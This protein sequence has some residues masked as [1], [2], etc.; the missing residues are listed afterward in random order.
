MVQ[1][2]FQS[3]AGTSNTWPWARSSHPGEQWPRAQASTDE[4]E[5]SQLCSTAALVR[6]EPR[7]GRHR[8]TLA[9]VPSPSSFPSHVQVSPEPC[10]RPRSSQ[11]LLKCPC[12]CAPGRAA[13][14][15]RPVPAHHGLCGSHTI[16]TA[17]QELLDSR[18][19]NAE[20]STRSGVTARV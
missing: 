1:K 14:P 17:E 20:G 12:P 3:L 18:T 11:Q 8:L 7:P 15:S 6:M 16:Q 5:M 2:T 10:P 13:S 4:L 19:T 9:Q